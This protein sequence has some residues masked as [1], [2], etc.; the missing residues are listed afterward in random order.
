MEHGLQ[1]D[2]NADE[3]STCTTHTVKLVHLHCAC[4]KNHSLY[5]VKMQLRIMAQSTSPQAPNSTFQTTALATQLNIMQNIICTVIDV[6]AVVALAEA[7]WV[8]GQ[9]QQDR[10]YS[11]RTT[12]R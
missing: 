3:G 10:A 1:R 5:R 2:A 6:A 8:A 7:S 12:D 11:D 4:N 9:L